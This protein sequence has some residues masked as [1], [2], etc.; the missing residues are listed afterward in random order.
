[1]SWWS[2]RPYVPVAERRAK[3]MRKMEKLA[4]KGQKFSPVSIAGRKISTT[5]WGRAWCDNLESYS[6]FSNRLPRGRTYVRNGSV[7]D[8]HIE[9]GRVTSI[10]CGSELYR[11][12]IK[13]KPLNGRSWKAIRTKCGQR[14]GS[15]VELLQGKLSNDVM[16]V[17]TER[18]SGL[19]PGP[20]EIDM[21]CSCPDWA[22]MC[23]HVAA[24]LYG[25][26]NR[27]DFKPELLFT[28]R[29]VD[30]MELIA[31]ADRPIITP[32]A[33]KRKSIAAADLT[34]VFGIEF[35]ESLAPE[36]VRT[37]AKSDHKGERFSAAHVPAS[38]DALDQNHRARQTRRGAPQEL[39]K[40]L[41]TSPRLPNE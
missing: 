27:L 8:L 3:A 13:I 38:R 39:R 30:Q 41:R 24:T 40:N 25:V 14:I 18:S 19:F 16:A 4:K 20:H 21:S 10:V 28:L 9:A 15:L 35:D 12:A 1:M 17:V 26:G 7:L 2:Y 29:Q 34:D 11:I 37:P 31:Q 32:A 23:K 22:G 36:R 33:G 5:F 6:D